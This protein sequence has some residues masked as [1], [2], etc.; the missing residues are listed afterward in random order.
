MRL[1]YFLGGV[2]YKLAS[3]CDK[4]DIVIQWSVQHDT[5]GLCPKLLSRAF[6]IVRCA[7]TPD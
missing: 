7:Y 3:R 5:D 4:E 2:P 6:L 1:G